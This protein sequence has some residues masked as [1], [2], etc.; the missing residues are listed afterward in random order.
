MNNWG[1]FSQ[2]TTR[3]LQSLH[4]YGLLRVARRRDGIRIYEAVPVREE[5][6]DGRER[7]RRLLA[8][9]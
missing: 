2:A 3:A 5:L 6:V 4:Y 1:G 8:R 7:L 9:S